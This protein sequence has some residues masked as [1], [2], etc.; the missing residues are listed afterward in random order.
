MVSTRLPPIIYSNPFFL[1]SAQSARLRILR[2]CAINQ[3][4]HDIPATP[5]FSDGVT[6]TANKLSICSATLP[7]LT[8]V[9]P[10]R[11]LSEFVKYYNSWGTKKKIFLYI[12]SL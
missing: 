2:T 10:R 12:M 1:Q 4:K 7:E 8:R 9:F 6:T 5:L 11:V 3:N